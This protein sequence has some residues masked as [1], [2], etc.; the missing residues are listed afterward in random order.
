[1]KKNVQFLSASDRL[2]YGD[3][4]FPII[5]K[6][7]LESNSNVS[8]KNY[9]LIKSDLSYFGALPT[10][11][12]RNLEQEN[13]KNSLII[14]GGGHVIF[15]NWSTLYGHINKLYLKSKKIKG[16][17]K[18]YRLL[19]FPRILFTKSKTISP[20]APYDLKGSLVYLSVGGNISTYISD[21]KVRKLLNDAALLSVRDEMLY[22]QLLNNNIKVKK[23][24]DTAILISKLFT[25]IKLSDKISNKL[26]FDV[27]QK[28][29]I[30]QIG[31]HYGPKDTSK[32]IKDINF[33]SKKGYRVLCMPIGLAADHED[34]KILLKLINKEPTWIYY[35]PKNIYEIMYLISHSDYFLGTSLH[36]CITAFA[37]NT[38]FIPLNKKVRKLNNYTK[39]WWTS[40]IG[41]SIDYDY[42]EFYLKNK[43]DSWDKV[44]ALEQL[45]KQQNIVM[46]NYTHL[47]DLVEGKKI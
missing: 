31:L 14:I 7:I 36:G 10:D 16:F 47:F 9:G 30:L 24:P 26:S 43:L 37:Y 2:N 39:T 11:S 29:I 18:L 12:Y 8:F 21:A 13:D 35:C 4:L 19:D 45:E 33:L 20:F 6:M 27:T 15:S 32:F 17:I 3:L 22:N 28:Y 1:M 42:L 5:T 34:Y 46:K 41:E 38:P 25:K 44:I 40:F 23:V